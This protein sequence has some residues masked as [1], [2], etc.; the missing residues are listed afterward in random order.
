MLKTIAY[1]FPLTADGTNFFKVLADLLG[2]LPNAIVGQKSIQL[3]ALHPEQTLPSIIFKQA[4]ISFPQIHLDIDNL[5]L[6]LGNF[7][8]NPSQ[9]FHAGELAPLMKTTKHDAYGKYV[10]VD[11]GNLTIF[12]LPISE[13]YDRL[14]GHI[15]RIDHTGINL[16]SALVSRVSWEQFISELARNCNLYR[17]PSGEDWPFILPATE[18]EFIH[19]ISDFPIGREPKF[20]LV[21]DTYSLVPTIQIDIET[22]LLRSEVE[23]LFP[24]P[25]GISFPDLAN[26]FRTV[27]IDHDWPGLAIR[28]DLRF[29]NDKPDGDWETGK[30]LVVDGGRIR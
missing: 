20:E 13:L 6:E 4:D 14:R 21:Y 10:T 28:F 3:T 1:S 23:Q 19:D 15:T 25:Y 18:E 17:Y 16:P 29:K 7:S 27:Y 22:D 12:R 30:W 24:E 9:T 5:N 8:I 11:F 2:E 26:Y